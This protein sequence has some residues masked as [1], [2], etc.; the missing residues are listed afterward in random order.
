MKTFADNTDTIVENFT[1][2]DDETIKS[3]DKDQ[4][5]A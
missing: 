5:D 1:Q 2:T 3:L 4:Q